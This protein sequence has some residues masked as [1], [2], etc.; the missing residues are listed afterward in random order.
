MKKIYI[1]NLSYDS[2]VKDLREMFEANRHR[3]YDVYIVEDQDGK[4]KGF[5]YVKFGDEESA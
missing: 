2:T 3:P 4:S 5:G 1:A